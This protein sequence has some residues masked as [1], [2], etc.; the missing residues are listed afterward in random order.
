MRLT[1]DIDGKNRGWWAWGI[2][3]ML[4]DSGEFSRVELRRTRHGY[5][6][7]AS[8]SGMSTYEIDTLRMSLG[9]DPLRVA[10]DMVKHPLQPRQ[11]LWKVK[12]N[13]QVE[14]LDCWNG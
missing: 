1:L 2:Y 3:Y 7:V 5:H 4:R 14:T 6:I 8:G 11:V 12:N 13:R 10:I 9:D